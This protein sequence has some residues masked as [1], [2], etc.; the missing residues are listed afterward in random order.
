MSEFTLTGQIMCQLFLVSLPCH[1]THFKKLLSRWYHLIAVEML[2]CCTVKL[3]SPTEDCL[4]VCWGRYRGSNV[5]YIMGSMSDYCTYLYSVQ[6]TLP[7]H[8]T[9]YTPTN[10]LLTCKAR[11]FDHYFG[12]TIVIYCVSNDSLPTCHDSNQNSL[13]TF[14]AKSSNFQVRLQ[15]YL[16]GV[17]NESLSTCHDSGRWGIAPS[18][19]QNDS[20]SHR[21]EPKLVIYVLR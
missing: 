20:Q 21:S 4:Y 5:T 2:H 15:C 10:S 19:L 16:I 12:N 1:S 8:C 9:V 18:M 14:Y 17:S 7:V 3:R 11:K 13:F 6:C